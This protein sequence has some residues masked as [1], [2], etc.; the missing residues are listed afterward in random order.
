MCD[1]TPNNKP[2]SASTTHDFHPGGVENREIKQR[3]RERERSRMEVKKL[4]RRRPV[5]LYI[6]RVPFLRGGVWFLRIRVGDHPTGSRSLELARLDSRGNSS[7]SLGYHGRGQRFEAE[8]RACACVCATRGKGGR[9]G[10]SRRSRTCRF[11]S[12]SS[13]SSFPPLPFF[14]LSS[15]PATRA[16]G[17]RFGAESTRE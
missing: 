1:A 4:T 14:L 8:P 12:P 13:P 5:N 7:S 11:P 10:E 6:L 9:E 15:D 17:R 3:E 2:S 16:G